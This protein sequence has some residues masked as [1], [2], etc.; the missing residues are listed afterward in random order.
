MS[1]HDRGLVDAELGTRPGGLGA[2]GDQSAAAEA[3][4]IAYRL[5][6]HAVTDR[7]RRAVSDRRVTIRPAPDTMTLVTGL[8]PAA[9]GVAVHVA[10]AKHADSLR[11]RGDQRSRGQIMADT[12]VERVTGQ[13]TADEV[14]LEVNVVMTQGAL[15]GDEQAPA[16]LK[17]TVH[18]HSPRPG[19]GSRDRRPGLAPPA[20]AAPVTGQLVGM[21]SAHRRFTGQLR[22]FVVFVTRD[23]NAVV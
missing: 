13:T 23:P 4:R 12:F 10:L 2:L 19:L 5:D 20:F 6:P 11:A 22:R 9:Q 16:Q 21:D 8:L 1:R 7:A 15:L 18:S 17:A 14:P 3:R